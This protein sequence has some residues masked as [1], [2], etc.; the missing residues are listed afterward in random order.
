M[1]GGIGVDYRVRWAR[2]G[3]LEIIKHMYCIWLKIYT[4]DFQPLCYLIKA[5]W[6]AS[7][8]CVV[9]SITELHWKYLQLTVHSAIPTQQCGYPDVAREFFLNEMLTILIPVDTRIRLSLWLTCGRCLLTFFR[10]VV[11]ECYICSDLRFSYNYSE[12]WK[13]GE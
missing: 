8:T 2:K 10:I 5:H 1:T 7:N 13:K 4:S 9:S 6:I 3:K 11:S 12:R